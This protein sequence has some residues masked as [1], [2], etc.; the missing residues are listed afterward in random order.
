M[1][2]VV[3]GA[4]VLSRTLPCALRESNGR[5]ELK[6]NRSEISITKEELDLLLHFAT[7]NCNYVYKE[8]TRS[9]GRNPPF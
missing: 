9:D 7:L 4:I 3:A 8:G 1:P 2:S 6:M 5:S